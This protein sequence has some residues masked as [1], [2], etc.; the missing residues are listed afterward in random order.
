MKENA[1]ELLKNSV[2]KREKAEA[3]CKAKK[4]V[5]K[6]GVRVI[7]TVC[8]AQSEGDAQLV[9]EQYYDKPGKTYSGREN[10]VPSAILAM[11]ELKLPADK[12]GILIMLM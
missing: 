8:T 5:R 1:R 7:Q 9:Q 2:A 6:R 11:E 3:A 4:K 10:G 12:W